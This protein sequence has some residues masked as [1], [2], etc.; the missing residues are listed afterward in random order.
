MAIW[1]KEISGQT[2]FK[3]GAAE[4]RGKKKKTEVTIHPKKYGDQSP[5]C[6]V[7][8]TGGRDGGRWA[9]EEEEEEE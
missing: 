1:E 2:K 4:I 5:Q 3:T 6:L 9:Q 7:L 8:C